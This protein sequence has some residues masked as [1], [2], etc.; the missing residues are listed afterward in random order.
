MI[1]LTLNDLVNKLEQAR[2]LAIDE[3]NTNAMIQATT[4]ISKL[5]GLDRIVIKNANVNADK[6]QPV[7]TVIQ[8]I[9][10]RKPDKI[11]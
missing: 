3:R 6:V 10:A 9:D 1:N 2:R 8:M 5:I 4:T 7:K 11:H